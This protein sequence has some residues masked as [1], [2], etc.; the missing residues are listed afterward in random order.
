[1]GLVEC[2][3]PTVPDE[4][5][6]VQKIIFSRVGMIAAIFLVLMIPLNMIGGLVGERAERQR[7]VVQ[8]IA[9]SNYGR[10]VVAGLVLSLPYREEYEDWVGDEKNSDGKNKRLEVRSIEHVARFFPVEQQT[11]GSIAV[12]T[13]SRG[14]FKARIFEAHAGLNGYFAG[15]GKMK[16]ARNRPGSKITWG[17]PFVSLAMDDPRGLIGTPEIRWGEAAMSLSRGSA[18]PR[19]A[20]GVHAAV[21]EFNPLIPWRTGFNV[22][23]GLNGTESLAMVPV[24]G[25]DRIKFSSEWPHPSF[26]G[27]FL[28][29]QSVT[30]DDGF[31]GNWTIGALASKSQQQILDQIEGRGACQGTGICADRLEVR[32]V[33]PIDIYS[34]SDRAVK[35]GFLFIALTFACFLLIEL[36]RGL[37]IHPAQYFLVGLALAIFFL[38]LIA[39]S[40]HIAFGM[41]YAIATG[42]CVALLGYYLSA[43]LGGMRAAA[44]FSAMLASLYAAL[45]GLLISE[46]NALLLGALLVFGLLAVAMIVTR[47]FDWYAL[48]IPRAAPR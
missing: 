8:E 46:D 17:T 47:K 14:I 23:L 21:P 39:L 44:G 6:Y 48:A 2:G 20:G 7:G 18:L 29:R 31:E 40:E 5:A 28:P 12:S 11:E 37:T 35:Y 45:Y 27:Q 22:K 34:L 36:I 25:S 42:A 13:K 33:E 24:A 3:A 32:F 30:R 16:L 19:M 38:L 43:V 10:Q 1:M 26:A 9:S 15:D 41:A 4:E